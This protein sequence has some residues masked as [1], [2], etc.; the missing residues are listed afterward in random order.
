MRPTASLSEAQRPERSQHRSSQL[1]RQTQ[2]LAE[3]VHLNE[4]NDLGFKRTPFGFQADSIWVSSGLQFF[5]TQNL[6]RGVWPQH[7]EM[8]GDD[9]EE[10]GLAANGKTRQKG[11]NLE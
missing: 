2:K 5:G 1:W 6:G 3:D 7:E 8:G 9:R 10:G 4:P 11:R